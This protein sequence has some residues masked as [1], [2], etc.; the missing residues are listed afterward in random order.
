MISELFSKKGW[1]GR[2]AAAAIATATLGAM[3]VSTIEPAQARFGGGGFGGG[4]LFVPHGGFGGYR[5]GFGG[6]RGGYGGYR[7]YGY[8][9]YG[10]GFGYGIGGFGLGLALGSGLGYGYGYPGYGGYYGGYYGAGY[11]GYYGYGGC[12][13]R[14]WGPFGPHLVNVCY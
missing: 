14:V 1:T 9:G 5:G 6:Y 7:G 11:G 4:H 13:R 2:L 12:L 10:R 3:T 8:R